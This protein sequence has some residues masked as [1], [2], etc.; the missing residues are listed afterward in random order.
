LVAKIPVS[1]PTVAIQVVSSCNSL[2]GMPAGEAEVVA[3]VL[4]KPG[5]Y[6]SSLITS[7]FLHPRGLCMCGGDL[8]VLDQNGRVV[9]RIS[10]VEG[11]LKLLQL[12][13]YCRGFRK[14]GQ[15]HANCN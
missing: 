2:I 14:S 12:F 11:E 15:R 7:V 1:M 3:G 10:F 6:G 8:F 13:Q 4:G 5:Y 9:R